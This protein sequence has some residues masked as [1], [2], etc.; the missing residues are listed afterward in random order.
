[1][2]KREPVQRDTKARILDAAL[3]VFGD[4]GFAASS[5]DDVAA[6]AGVTKGAVYYYF[7]DKA[8]LAT[9][10][11]QV[12]WDDLTTAALQVYAA[13]QPTAVNLQS[14]FEVF[15]RHLRGLPAARGFLREAWFTPSLDPPGRASH[16]AAVELVASLLEVGIDRGEIL[17]FDAEVLAR[18]LL[19]ALMEA[20]LHLL[21]SG[22]PDAT[23]AVVDHLVTSLVPERARSKRAVG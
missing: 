17:P 1:M 16:E 12:V 2:A 15:V 23:L 7:N 21:G 9:D 18:V 22:D 8:D 13:D 19:G 14:C 10:L 20:T 3:A 5:V 11:Q 6:A 4:K